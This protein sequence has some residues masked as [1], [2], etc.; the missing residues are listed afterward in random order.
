MPL[1]EVE[2]RRV[3]PI[4]VRL[5]Q[6]NPSKSSLEKETCD[7]G[8]SF[9]DI[10]CSELLSGDKENDCGNTERVSGDKEHVNVDKEPESDDKEPES[11]DKEPESV[12]KEP[13]VGTGNFTS[14]LINAC[15]NAKVMTARYVN[16]TKNKLIIE[17]L[18][19]DI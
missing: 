2:S 17:G 9:D 18:C 12:D 8:D 3:S 1:Q 16:I 14:V 7:L 4:T 11:V 13:S 19:I 15:M 6:T 5:S 10:Y